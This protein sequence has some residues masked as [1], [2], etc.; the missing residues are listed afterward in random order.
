[1][2]CP[3]CWNRDDFHRRP[4]SAEGGDLGSEVYTAGMAAVRA[5]PLAVQQASAA[6]AGPIPRIDYQL[7]AK[8]FDRLLGRQ[9]RGLDVVR[10]HVLCSSAVTTRL[11]APKVEAVLT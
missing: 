11:D 6:L 4:G 8:A 9:A 2:P 5:Q 1:M 3:S 10:Q 7:E